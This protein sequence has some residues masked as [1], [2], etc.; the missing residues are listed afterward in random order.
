MQNVIYSQQRYLPVEQ[1]V[2][3]QGSTGG[4]LGSG[5]EVANRG[6]IRFY[7]RGE[8]GCS[9]KLTIE[10]EVPDILAPFGG[11]LTPVVEGILRTDMGKFAE[12]ATTAHSPVSG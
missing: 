4:S 11:A 3:M 1:P 5:V 10:Y 6:Q 9:I 2:C 12:Y 8:S 7:P